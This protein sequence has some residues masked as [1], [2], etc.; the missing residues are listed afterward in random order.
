MGEHLLCFVP[1]INNLLRPVA[2]YL[3]LINFF[4]T[5]SL[6]TQNH[7]RFLPNILLVVSVHRNH[8]CL[9]FSCVIVNSKSPNLSK[10]VILNVLCCGK[11][12]R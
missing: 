12:G 5:Q 3:S 8:K 7:L 9:I 6:E 1:E 11:L 2:T 4:K 10:K